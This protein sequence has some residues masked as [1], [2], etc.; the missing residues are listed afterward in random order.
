M[1]LVHTNKAEFSELFTQFFEDCAPEIEAIPNVRF[2]KEPITLS[3]TPGATKHLNLDPAVFPDV[4]N[5]IVGDFFGHCRNKDDYSIQSL[6]LLRNPVTWHRY[7]SEKKVRRRLAEDVDMFRDEILF[8]GTPKRKLSSILQNNLDPR[9][10][11]RANYGK[12]VYFSDSIEKCMQYVDL[13]TSMEQ[14][15]SIILCCVLLGKVWIEPYEKAQRKL[16]SNTMF[17]PEGYDSAV[18]HDSFK[19]WIV[20]EKSQVLPLCVINFK[21]SNNP[22]CFHRLSSHSVLFQG[23]NFYPT[24]MHLIQTICN[25]PTPTDTNAPSSVP[26]KDDSS[27]K[28]PTPQEASMLWTVLNIPVGEA[29]IR[30]IKFPN[31][32]EF[33][34]TAKNLDDRTV[35]F[36]INHAQ[37]TI[38][39]GV[40]RNIQV[41]EERNKMDTDRTF[42][43]RSRQRLQ[44]EELIN[45]V[46]ECE[47]LIVKYTEVKPEL[48][49][50]EAEGVKVNQTIDL[51][52]AQAFHSG[53]GRPD[54][55]N[56]HEFQLAV[57][58]YQNR[59]NELKQMYD[60][61]IAT[62]G[63]LW[64]AE[65]VGKAIQVKA[66]RQQ[67]QADV[68]ADHVK[69]QRQLSAIE[70]EKSKARTQAVSCSTIV[71]LPELEAR[72][73]QAMNERENPNP[74][75]S[76]VEAFAFKTTQVHTYSSQIWAQVV[77]ELLMPT[78]MICQ[79]P[80]HR[81][82][83]LNETNVDDIGV[84][85]QMLQLK[86]VGKWYEIAPCAFFDM[87]MASTAFWPVHPQNKLPN[88]RLFMMK[89]F[90]EWIF[91][92]KERRIRTTAQSR[93]RPGMMSRLVRDSLKV[94]E[95]P[96]F[97]LDVLELY[98]EEWEKLDPC[99][100]RA[101]KGLKSRNGTVVFNRKERQEELDK[102]GKDLI[103]N[104]FVMADS[105]MLILDESS[106]KATS[107][108]ISAATTTTHSTSSSSST[109]TTT[110][111]TTSSPTSECPICQDPLV[112]PEPGKTILVADQVVKLKSCRHCFHQGCIVEWFKAKDSQLKC[113]MCNVLCTTRGLTDA[114]KDA[115][116]G[117][118]AKLGPMPDGYM[119]YTFDDRLACYFL[120]VNIPSSKTTSTDGTA[121]NVPPDRRYATVPVTAKLGPLLMIRLI[122]LFYYGH[123]FRV[124]DSVTRGI[125]NVV[126]WNGVHLRTGMTGAYGFPAPEFESSCWQEI[127]Q[128]GVAMG[129]DEL[130]LSIPQTTPGSGSPLVDEPEI[131]LPEGLAAEMSAQNM[132]HKILHPDRAPLFQL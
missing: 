34:V 3:D 91:L 70:V 68:A 110:T 2:D 111:T 87:P 7:Q 108:S 83:L 95:D 81:M 36:Y 127:N 20:Y 27:W 114:T 17:L 38:L 71:T 43:E 64:N 5:A 116:K 117:S 41:L 119:A 21:S 126:I 89:D 56:T 24:S 75:F 101:L 37:W 88:R 40:A 47:A 42:M 6:R 123:M 73:Q 16:D 62:L 58:P 61:K 122:C 94:D 77:A 67:L 31:H 121:A 130:L 15:Y 65:H 93:S 105:D 29:Q 100:L 52:K 98:R 30:K 109:A 45:S 50:I 69:E 85:L 72:I 92:E 131:V 96:L 8:H 132:I 76:P 128:K 23:L 120:Y 28:T 86:G 35:Y 60:G 55:Y 103:G 39:I 4:C 74:A 80:S 115:F 12:G 57:H 14:E 49:A 129:L 84:K 59:L 97:G 107:V 44:I 1:T 125:S 54:I 66:W 22:D 13:Q 63:P 53:A 118:V 82:K 33:A 102:L 11:V 113:P 79:M 19:E 18:G 32:E 25:V 26:N 10:T 78:L 9:T 90:V 48:D 46:P 112:I 99:I 106:H 124:G 51:L 104:L